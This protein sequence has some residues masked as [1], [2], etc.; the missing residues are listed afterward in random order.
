EMLEP[1]HY[2]R[3]VIEHA[4]QAGTPLLIDDAL[5]DPRFG[6]AESVLS[7]QL[8][9]VLCFPIVA[10]GRALAAIYLENNSGSNCFR[11]FH[12][13]VVRMLAGQISV[14]ME[15]GL[16]FARIEEMNRELEARVQARTRELEEAGRELEAKNDELTST[17]DDLRKTQDALVQQEKL[18][19]V[20]R[21]AAGAT[22]EINNPLNFV[23]GGAYAVDRKVAQVDALVRS[24]ELQT[25]RILKLVQET[26]GLCAI[27]ING[28]NRIKNIVEG[29]WNVAHGREQALESYDIRRSIEST[30]ALVTSQ[31]RPGLTIETEL[32]EIPLIVCSPGHIDQLFLN[33]VLNAVDAMDGRGTIRLR[34]WAEE[35]CVAASVSDTGRGIPAEIRNQIFEPFFTSKPPGKGAGLGLAICMGIVTRRGGAITVESEPGKGATFIVRL[36]LQLPDG[37]REQP[38]FWKEPR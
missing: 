27:L 33:L 37:V 28:G 25:E 20:G 30:V 29:L 18:A 36:P 38:V 1:D 7:H 22:H 10:G 13:D 17:L 34:C 3:S 15:N 8:R 19:S 11:P 4:L 12:V 31:P 32:A 6:A 2:S 9:S 14:A 5:L 21:L 26:R 23:Q 35:G 24:S 16:A